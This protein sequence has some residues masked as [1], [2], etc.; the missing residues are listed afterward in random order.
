MEPQIDDERL[1][2]NPASNGVN[3]PWWNSWKFMVPAWIAVAGI[4]Y[5]G[6]HYNVDERVI[7]GI[8]FVLGILSNAFAWILGIIALVPVVGP[9]I[10]KVITFWFIWLVNAIG[11]VI[12]YIA[13]R[14]GYSKDV[15]TYRGLTIATIVGIVIGYVLGKIF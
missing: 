8:V 12:S 1:R 13:L 6:L 4:I 10:V 2:S 11:Y 3:G 7:A 9:F 15:L 14:R 5:L